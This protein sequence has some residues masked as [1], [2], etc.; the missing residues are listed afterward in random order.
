MALAILAAV[1]LLP[2]WQRLSEAR[3][4]R[5]ELA[6]AVEFND[7][8][9]AYNQRLIEAIRTDPLLTER[10]LMDQENLRRPGEAAVRADWVPPD[11]PLT[12]L[13]AA[14]TLQPASTSKPPATVA[15][16]A[17]HLR[18]PRTR[19]GL[20]FLAGLMMVAATVLFLPAKRR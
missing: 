9:I 17:E 12:A 14:Q 8:L 4:H 7:R 3:A 2:A 10:L 5:D 18:Q 16:L 13:L 6:A 11:P 1:T 20:L 15:A 19:R